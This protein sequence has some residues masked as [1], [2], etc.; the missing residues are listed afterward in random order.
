MAFSGPKVALEQGEWFTPPRECRHQS[1]SRHN[2]AFEYLAKIREIVV[3]RLAML[4][5]PDSEPRN[6]QEVVVS[7]AA[8]AEVH[9]EIKLVPANFL[10]LLRGEA[11]V[12]R[13]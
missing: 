1:G 4:I 9:D 12:A 7:A 2:P 3:A 5:E 10:D 8:A 6:A 11:G 13:Q